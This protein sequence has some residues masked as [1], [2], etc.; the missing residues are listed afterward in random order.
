MTA[1]PVA[2]HIGLPRTGTTTLQRHLFARHSRIHYLG[3]FRSGITNRLTPRRFGCRD[4]RVAELMRTLLLDGSDGPQVERCTELWREIGARA[5]GK[6]M[7]WSWEG[8][9]TDVIEVRE[10]RARNLAAVMAPARVLLTLRHPVSLIESTYFQILRR[11]NRWPTGLDVWYQPIDAWLA[12]NL[13]GE[14]DPLLDYER[15]IDLYCRCFGRE[16]AHVL[17]FEELAHDAD[18][19]VAATCRV[20]A[21]PAAEGVA[22]ARGRHENRSSAALIERT[23]SLKG[24]FL[25][26]LRAALAV[27]AQLRSTRPPA[28][29][30][31]PPRL[32]AAARAL[33]ADR[34]RAG[35]RRLAERF[36]LELER[37]GY[38]M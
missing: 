36:N 14:L 12:D 22:L 19:F 16:A 31:N 27:S 5:P 24:S 29:S 8:L 30:S 4:S 3:M 37:W 6:S 34:T 26:R 2:I 15:T 33:I 10:R 21:V 9:T 28:A 18:R 32:G 38:P 20:L 17:L 1:P 11:N 25:G 13:A 7:V 23:R 35:N